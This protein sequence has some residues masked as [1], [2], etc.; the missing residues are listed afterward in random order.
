MVAFQARTGP[1]NL[2]QVSPAQVCNSRTF[3]GDVSLTI[4]VRFTFFGWFIKRV[5]DRQDKQDTQSN[6]RPV[7]NPTQE[8]AIFQV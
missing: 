6:T 4:T 7:A 2:G 3:D 1:K 5:I 8:V